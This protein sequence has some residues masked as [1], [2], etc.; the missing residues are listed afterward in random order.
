MDL[1][2]SISVKFYFDVSRFIMDKHFILP[3]RE[4]KGRIQ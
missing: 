2:S 3:V 1:D 4:G